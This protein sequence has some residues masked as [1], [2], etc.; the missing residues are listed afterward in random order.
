MR[1]IDT[2]PQRKQG[3]GF[4]KGVAFT[5]VQFSNSNPRLR[6]GLVT[7]SMRINVLPYKN[8]T[9]DWYFSGLTGSISLLPPAGHPRVNV[10]TEK[11]GPFAL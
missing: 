1:T 8:L 9:V 4:S 2:S 5:R 10:C 7:V 6:C 11:P 3:F